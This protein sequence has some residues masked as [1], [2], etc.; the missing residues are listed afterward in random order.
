MRKLKLLIAAI[1]VVAAV[2]GAAQAKTPK[3]IWD[4]MYKTWEQCNDVQGIVSLFVYYPDSIKQYFPTLDVEL[5]DNAEGWRYQVFEY[6]WKKPRMI[7]I[8]YALGRNIGKDMVGK[9]LESKPGTRIVFGVKDNT[10]IYAKF[11]PTGD[12]AIYKQIEKQIF[13]VPYNS[14]AYSAAL[15]GGLNFAGT[16]DDVM[17]NK[18]HYFDDGKITV[19]EVKERPQKVDFSLVG[20]KTKFNQ[21]SV[22]GGF[23][24]MTFTPKNAAKNKGIDK[25]IV[26]INKQN[27]FPEQLEVYHKGMLVACFMIDNVKMNQNMDNSLWDSFYK[28]AKIMPSS[29][30]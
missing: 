3:E 13:Y 11:P 27:S 7:H 19:A 17:K 16:L 6:T 29:A 26:Y 22:P 28:G 25:E 18:K 30:K 2:S 4:S 8:K 21:K 1:A 23:Y 12:I 15:L 14:D 10:N 9:L 20:G 5:K 24:M